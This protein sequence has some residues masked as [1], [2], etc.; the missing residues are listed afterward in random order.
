MIYFFIDSVFH[1]YSLF[2]LPSSHFAT[3]HYRIPAHILLILPSC[4]S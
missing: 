2:G 1:A 3:N 4:K